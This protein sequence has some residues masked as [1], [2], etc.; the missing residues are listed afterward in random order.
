MK[1]NS[2]Q[3]AAADRAG[4]FYP[5]FG[6]G[7]NNRFIFRLSV[8]TMDKIEV[9]AVWDTLKE[10]MRFLLFYLVPAHMRDLQTGRQFLDLALDDVQTIEPTALFG[11]RIKHL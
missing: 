7:D 10:W 3:I 6:L 5:V 2:H 8:I 4:E 1:L 11:P 9:G